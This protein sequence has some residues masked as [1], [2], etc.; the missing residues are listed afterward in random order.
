MTNTVNFKE[1]AKSKDPKQIAVKVS[2]SRKKSGRAFYYVN[3]RS[4]LTVGSKD[5][6]QRFFQTRDAAEQLCTRINEAQKH[7]GFISETAAGTF[8]EI[9]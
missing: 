8:D 5:N 2:K 6:G 1:I 3:Y 9:A 4:V 7:G